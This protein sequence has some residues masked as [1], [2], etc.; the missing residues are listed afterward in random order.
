M[1]DA[2]AVGVE[3][4]RDLRAIRRHRRQGIDVGN[5]FVHRIDQPRRGDV[6]EPDP[7]GVAVR[8]RRHVAHEN[9]A[10][11]RVRLVVGAE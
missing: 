5:A 4:N 1:L 7:D 11:H 6:G 9:A 3:V 2:F 10:D 8:L